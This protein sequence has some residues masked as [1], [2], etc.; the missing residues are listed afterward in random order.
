MKIS[1]PTIGRIALTLALVALALV[2][3]HLGWDHYREAP[4]TRD[5]RVRADVIQIAPDVS[6]LVER[7]AV[8]D[9][10]AVRRGELLFTIDRARFQLAVEQ[11]DAT[12]QA[13]RVQIDQARRENRRNVTLG[14][15]VPAELREQGGTKVDQLKAN[16]L[17]ASAALDTARLNLAR[18]EVKASVDGW[19]TNLD[20]RPGAYATAGRPVFALVDRNSLHVQG[21]FEETKLD[22]IHVGAPVR[23]RMIGDAQWL[24][25]H[26]DSIAAGIE[27]RERSGS[28][29]LL[30]NV[31][32]T[33][34]WV[35]LAQ[36]IPVRVQLDRVPQDTRL[37]MGRT[38]TVE[39]VETPRAA[40]V[41]VAQGAQ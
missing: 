16:L 7:V 18:T 22:R 30:A 34:N 28:S 41:H 11:A 21:Y 2:V 19:V 13:L 37:I 14:D 23:V 38:A 8:H 39:V 9:N 36:R 6:G 3:G 29:S 15:L 10:Q 35:R 1:L 25:G 26:I 12:V 27:D 4:W 32:P 31:N 24:D 5:G 33:F 17:Q 20:L 40:A